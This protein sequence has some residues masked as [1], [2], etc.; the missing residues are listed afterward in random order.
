M[1]E[2][3]DLLAEKTKL[4]KILRIQGIRDEEVLEA[5]INTPRE[6]FIP[7]KLREHAYDN[8][9][10]PIGFDQ[11]ISQPYTVAFMLEVLGVKKDDKI[12]EIGAG[13]G[14]NAALLSRITG[15]KGRVISVEIVRGLIEPAKKTLQKMG[16]S[17]VE[18]VFGDGSVGY[19]EEAPYDKI[20][21]TAASPKMNKEWVD[22]L[23][24]GG[25]IVAPIGEYTQVMT[26]ATKT[27]KGLLTENIGYFTFVPLTGKK[28]L[29]VYK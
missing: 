3:N 5:I 16:C 11:T 29:N 17:N 23:K 14:Y 6:E 22:Q 4:L 12:L 13:S 27:K 19:E 2:E 7:R 20:I 24:I 18:I 1:R 21:V 9:P 15:E 10:L 8:N 26:K 28:G 25:V